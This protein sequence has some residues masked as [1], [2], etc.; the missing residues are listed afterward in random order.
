MGMIDAGGARLREREAS[1]QW[2]NEVAAMMKAQPA[3]PPEPTVV[4]RVV[5]THNGGECDC[6]EGPAERT[7]RVGDELILHH[8]CVDGRKDEVKATVV[9]FTPSPPEHATATVTERTPA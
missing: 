1:R 8:T 7:L 9:R 5:E 6:I 3:T 4:V 2:A